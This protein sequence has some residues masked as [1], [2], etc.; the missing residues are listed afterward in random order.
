MLALNIV[1]VYPIQSPLVDTD[2]NNAEYSTEIRCGIVVHEYLLKHARDYSSK[3]FPMLPVWTACNLSL[4]RHRLE[5]LQ[6]ENGTERQNPMVS[7]PLVTG[8]KPSLLA[9]SRFRALPPPSIK[10]RIL[11]AATRAVQEIR[12]RLSY[13]CMIHVPSMCSIHAVYTYVPLPTT[14]HTTRKS[15]RTKTRQMVTKAAYLHT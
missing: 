7:T 14:K 4:Q 6:E 8:G 11:T 13:F 9:A 5:L 1:P 10:Q 15:A 12:G 2:T 3:N